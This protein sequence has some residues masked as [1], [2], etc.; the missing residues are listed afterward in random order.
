MATI[1]I[2]IYSKYGHIATMAEEVKKGVEATGA[3][4]QIYQVA[5]IPPAESTTNY[6]VITASQLPEADGFLFGIPTR[7]GS[8]PA[9]MKAL[10]D[11]TGQLW[12]KGLLAGKF[13]G[14]FFS[15]GS[16]HGGQETTAF[17]TITFFTHLGIN[18]VPLGY[19]N[20]HLNDNSE[21]IGGG[22]WGAGTIA[23][24]DGS[25]QP[26]VKEKEVA[27]TQGQN[28]ATTVSTFIKGKSA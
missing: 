4:V 23:G 5:E 14:I 22:P 12:V 19:A 25:R 21:V 2:I 26:S 11:S 6:P 10:F 9:Q 27:F 28:F 13:A 3:K 16:Q 20:T 1:F 24:G 18:F 17:T 15:T 7:Y 8:T